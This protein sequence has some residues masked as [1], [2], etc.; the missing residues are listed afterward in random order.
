MQCLQCF[1]NN[2]PSKWKYFHKITFYAKDW[3]ALILRRRFS[4]GFKSSF[5]WNRQMQSAVQAQG[6]CRRHVAASP[7]LA[8]SLCFPQSF[9][10]AGDTSASIQAPWKIFQEKSRI[11]DVAAC[12]VSA[13]FLIKCFAFL[14]FP[15]Y[16]SI[17]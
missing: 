10:W 2:G 14:P 9:C 1:S 16:K 11:T 12:S 4:V 7:L 8:P 17:C 13:L 3:K 6:Q 15:Q 5:L